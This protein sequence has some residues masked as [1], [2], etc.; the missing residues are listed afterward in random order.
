MKQ[1]ILLL[2]THFLL[3]N[4]FGQI[5]FSSLNDIFSYADKNSFISRQGA[6]KER[7]NNS[8]EGI[9]KSAL[10]PKVN[11]FGV[12]EYYPVI[13]S[14]VVPGKLLGARDDSYQKVQFGL[15]Y[16]FSGGV[17]VS[18]PVVNFEKWEQLKLARLQ[19]SLNNL[20]TK[21]QL[22]NLHI[23]L[24]QLY[25]RALLYKQLIQ[26]NY[27]NE[28][29]T[30]EL[31]RIIEV[32][33]KN[34]IVNPADYNRSQN[35]FLEVINAGI[36]YR[37][38]YDLTL[39]NLKVT[40]NIN[41]SETILL[42]ETISDVEAALLREE[43]DIKKRAAFK[44]AEAQVAVASQALAASKKLALPKVSFYGRYAYQL[45][46]KPGKETQQVN[47]DVSSLGLRLDV[48]LFAGRYYKLQT[49]KSNEQY[50]LS[51]LQQEQVERSLQQEQTTWQTNY[52]TAISKQPQ[53]KRK[54]ALAADNLRI[55]QLSFKEGVM[56][57]DEFNNIF[58]EHLRTQIEALQNTADGLV[59]KLLLTINN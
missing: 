1:F 10:L 48:P 30:A 16:N 36:E 33:K 58:L 38:L 21:S 43:T 29:V 46:V 23:N 57:F 14:M 39:N 31:M 42:K 34:N 13:G 2:V 47:F 15:P 28:K 50:Q 26:L 40:A 53:L 8:E 9:S 19:S 3:L 18:M 17:E 51:K 22:E 4:T 56:E 55:A 6:V 45:Q 59:H 24:A 25:Y 52:N 41:S 35:L 27:E 32:R 5:T 54:T 20:D 44:Q 11:V 37:K 7:I 49:Q 12:A